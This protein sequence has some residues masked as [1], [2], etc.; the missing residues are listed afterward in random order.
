[1]NPIIPQHLQLSAFAAIRSVSSK[2]LLFIGAEICVMVNMITKVEIGGEPKS[3]A[4]F[5]Y[6][7]R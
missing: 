6:A 7:L 2:Y 1:M 4:Y 3:N 5:L